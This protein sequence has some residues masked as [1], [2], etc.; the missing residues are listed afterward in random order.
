MWGT[1]AS[2]CVEILLSEIFVSLIL[3][4]SNETRLVFWTLN[5]LR[6]ILE[7]QVF[8]FIS[9]R[10]TPPRKQNLLIVPCTQR[11]QFV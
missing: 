11:D 1:S 7:L 2:G 9:F 6:P 4:P 10:I 3:P 8:E 5:Q